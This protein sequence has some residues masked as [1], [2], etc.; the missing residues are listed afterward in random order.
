[1]VLRQHI[2]WWDSKG[3]GAIVAAFLVGVVAGI[4]AVYY[5]PI[6]GN[7]ASEPIGMAMLRES[8]VP[9]KPESAF[10]FYVMGDTPYGWRDE[11]SLRHQIGDMHSHL[12]EKALFVIHLGDLQKCKVTNCSEEAFVKTKDYLL[13]LPLTTLVIP[14]DNDYHL[15]PNP[16]AGWHHFENHFIHSERDWKYLDLVR[17]LPFNVTR[18]EK[19]PEMF[20]FVRAGVLFLSVNLVDVRPKRKDLQEE[21]DARMQDNLFW[22]RTN[23]KEM[24]L[25]KDFRGVIIFGHSIRSPD[26]RPFFDGLEAIF[27]GKLLLIPVLYM[28]GDGHQFKIDD[29]FAQTT[30]W[31]SYRAVQVDRGGAADPILVEVARVVGSKTVPLVKEKEMHYVLGD[32]LYRIDR[33][34]GLYEGREEE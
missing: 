31:D 6:F 26:T 8:G 33:R 23:V 20:V 9:A 1:M 21:Y 3:R 4:M 28:H 17:S 22:V 15:C 19:R 10:A 11:A 16:K 18:W 7:S 12:H 24:A 32:G 25:R 2:F 29:R 5:G 14:G 30:G 34:M 13:Q 27:K